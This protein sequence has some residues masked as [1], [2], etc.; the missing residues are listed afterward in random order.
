M[1]K[2]VDQIKNFRIK[3]IRL[4]ANMKGPISDE[5]MTRMLSTLGPKLYRR[6]CDLYALDFGVFGYP[7]N[8]NITFTSKKN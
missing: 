5:E 6:L 4:N 2:D 3:A 7:I 8:R 1:L